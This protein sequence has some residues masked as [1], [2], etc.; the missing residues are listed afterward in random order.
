MDGP[1]KPVKFVDLEK[2]MGKWYVIS[3]IPN[4]VENGCNDAYDICY[5]KYQ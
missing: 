1:E 3:A 2:F 4:F 5:N